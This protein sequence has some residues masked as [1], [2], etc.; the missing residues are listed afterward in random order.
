MEPVEWVDF[1][2]K[3]YELCNKG[4]ISHSVLPRGANILFIK[5]MGWT[6]ILLIDY[7]DINYINIENIYP[8]PLNDEL[9]DQLHSAQN[10]SNI[11]N[12]FGYHQLSMMK[13][14]IPNIEF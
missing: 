9:F 14:Y 5:N 13:Y 10:A 4:F 12:H 3:L 7:K 2:K 8:L 1:K 6:M 11:D